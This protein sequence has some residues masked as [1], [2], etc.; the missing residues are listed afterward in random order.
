MKL[1][2]K[3]LVLFL[4][5]CLL[6]AFAACG[7]AKKNE[8]DY[9]PADDSK[10]ASPRAETSLAYDSSVG[11]VSKE[12]MTA[13]GGVIAGKPGGGEP[14]DGL[15]SGYPADG[16]GYE[17]IY[18]EEKPVYEAG[19]ITASAWNEN[20]NYEFWKKLFRR[21]GRGRRQIL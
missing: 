5:F 7:M 8:V 6:F 14:G 12:T 17:E 11:Y 15:P 2:R 3:A 13:D 20:E 4:A 9:A 18:D 21:S 10:P 16:E 1:L 19:L